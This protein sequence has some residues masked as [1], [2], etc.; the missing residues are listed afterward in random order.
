M[1]DQEELNILTGLLDFYSDRATAHASFVIAGMFGIYAVILAEPQLPLPIIFPA[2]FALLFINVY[3]FLNFGYYAHVAYYIKI[4]LEGMYSHEIEEET[5]RELHNKTKFFYGF[6]QFK[7]LGMKG[8]TRLII[9]A[10]I[11]A[12]ATILP[13]V[14]RLVRDPI[15]D[16]IGWLC[17]AIMMGVI[18][19][20]VLRYII[21]RRK[22]NNKVTKSQVSK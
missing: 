22:A 18:S 7:D 9:F 17:L 8:N 3:S 19:I 21:R 13:F 11:F 16:S 15:L 20:A 5:K 10:V 14:W 12:V 2:F 1:R 6:G 4:K